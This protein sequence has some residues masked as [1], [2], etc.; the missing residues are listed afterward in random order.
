MCFSTTAANDLDVSGMSD[1]AMGKAVATCCNYGTAGTKKSDE[2][3]GDCVTIPRATCTKDG[4]AK[5]Q[6]TR[7]CGRGGLQTSPTATTEKTIC[8]KRSPFS[9]RFI[10]DSFEFANAGDATN[11]SASGNTGFKIAYIGATCT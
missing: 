3:A 2:G 5:R 10:S 7:Q 9:F 6:A 4:A 8:V 1:L 11:E